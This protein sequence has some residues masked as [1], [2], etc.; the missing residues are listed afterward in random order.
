[1]TVDSKEPQQERLFD[2]D[3]Y[4]PVTIAVLLVLPEAN[5]RSFFAASMIGSFMR[6]D[7]A[8]GRVLSGSDVGCIVV[9][10]KHRERV[11]RVLNQ[12]AAMAATGPRLGVPIRRAPMRTEHGL[13]VRAAPRGVLPRVRGRAPATVLAAPRRPTSTPNRPW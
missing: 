2:P 7:R 12:A 6:R 4:S 3:R 9:G 5:A 13:P 1:M 10:P 8:P 11:L